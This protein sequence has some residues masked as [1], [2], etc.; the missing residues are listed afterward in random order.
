[1]ANKLKVSVAL[2]PDLVRRLDRVARASGDSRSQLITDLV[3]GGLDQAEAMIKVTADPVMMGAIGRVMADPGVLR[4]MING[5]RSEL[6]DE[7]LALFKSRLDAMT[8]VVNE[9]PKA[10]RIPKLKG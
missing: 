7:Q 5:L 8:G 6:S 1:M 4:N 9:L 10:R 2:S 3:E